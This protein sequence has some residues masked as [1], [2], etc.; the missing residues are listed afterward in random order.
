MKEY[1]IKKNF[2]KAGNIG[3]FPVR[4]VV[5]A[6]VISVFFIWLIFKLSFGMSFKLMLLVITI[7]PTLVLC[8]YG[9]QGNSLSEIVYRYVKFH[10]FSK[11]SY[12]ELSAAE[13]GSREKRILQ[14]KRRQLER[15]KGK[16]TQN[17]ARKEDEGCET[18]KSSPGA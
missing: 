18:D 1:R 13:F 2:A 15:I 10:L 11:R 6:A 9:I 12:G 5:E 8:L 3:Q 7:F 16:E 14:I 4:N 17:E